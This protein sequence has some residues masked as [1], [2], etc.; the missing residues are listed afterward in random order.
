MDGDVTLLFAYMVIGYRRAVCDAAH[1]VNRAAAHQHRLTQH[2][3]ARRRVP[4]DCEIPD[5]RRLI[6]LHE[7]N[8]LILGP[9]ILECFGSIKPGQDGQQIF[10]AGNVFLPFAFQGL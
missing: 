9:W 5:I 10:M 7:S 3:L 6:R 2:C 4:D 8:W 1:P